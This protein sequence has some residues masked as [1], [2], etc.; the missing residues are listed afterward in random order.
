MTLVRPKLVPVIATRV[1]LKNPA[2]A[3]G[4][5]EEGKF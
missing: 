5:L 3:R 4:Y 1:K 2:K